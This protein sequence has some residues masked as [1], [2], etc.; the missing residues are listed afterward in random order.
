[1]R[2]FH[3]LTFLTAIVVLALLAG[4]SDSGMQEGLTDLP[5]TIDGDKIDQY[6]QHI[7][8]G[9]DF[10]DSANVDSAVAH[11]TAMAGLIPEAKFN[12]YHLACAYGRSGDTE[13][14]IESLNKLVESGWEEADALLN[15]GDLNILSEDS[16]FAAILD[17]ARANA[18]SG[19][20]SLAVRM[21]ECDKSAQTFGT[22]DELTSY[23]DSVSNVYR[24]HSMIWQ[25]SEYT[26]ASM[27][28]A[29]IRAADMR[30]LM[31]DST[32]Y[33][34]GLERVR[35]AAR[36]QSPYNPW[37][38]A[39]ESVVKEVDHYLSSSPAEEGADQANFLAGFAWTARTWEED[40]PL[41]AEV[42]GK[43]NAALEKVSEG[44][45]YYKPAQTV[46]A[47]NELEL[48]DG[49]NR[50][51]IKT[52]VRAALDGSQDNNWVKRV[53]TKRFQHDAIDM[54]WPIP[55]ES[56]DIDGKPVKL[57]DYAGKVLLIDFW[58]TWCPPC[59]AELPNVK[60]V[61]ERY[62]KNGFEIVSVSFDAEEH[63]P[64]DSLR[65]WIKD[66]GLAWKHI[67]DGKGWG[68]ELG[69]KYFVSSIPAPFM[70][71]KDG[72][73]FASGDD[74]Y[75]EELEKTVKAALAK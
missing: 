49:S 12:Y 1:M 22:V 43:S 44:S 69:A 28:L 51:A 55:F 41:R 66:N 42:L 75:G 53:V 26:K 33:D 2:K 71:G 21:P 7:N 74:C 60:D 13:K 23:Y 46:L 16:R 68:A 62:H 39:A 57:S 65:T 29:A 32:G 38:P 5:V 35:A 24:L 8:T 56:D 47:A 52:R 63:M 67:Y 25:N 27:Q 40:S 10:L 73:L 37:G 58:A 70:V 61:Y 50:E 9:Y 19:G 11:F 54:I 64:L 48:S 30:E 72:K 6:R 14:A 59:R 34:Y 31:K 3:R 15:D 45:E 36:V 4:C 20:A 18:E 17:K